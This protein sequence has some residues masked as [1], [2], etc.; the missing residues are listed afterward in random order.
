[1]EMI[2]EWHNEA[3]VKVDHLVKIFEERVDV[4][5]SEELSFLERRALR[6]LIEVFKTSICPSRKFY[7]LA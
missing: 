1:M 7:R 6:Y 3:R 5:G 2:D 4:E